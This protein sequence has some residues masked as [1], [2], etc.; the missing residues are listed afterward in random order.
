MI[1]ERINNTIESSND[2]QRLLSF[3]CQKENITFALNGDEVANEDVFTFN[4]L[5]PALAF[6]SF[7]VLRSPF[8][9]TIHSNEKLDMVDAM[10]P[11]YIEDKT[12]EELDCAVHFE[13][14]AVSLMLISNYLE[15]LRKRLA[16]DENDKKTSVEIELAPMVVTFKDAMD[17]QYI[18]KLSPQEATKKGIKTGII[19]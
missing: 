5:L 8:G 4:R 2:F 14:K 17:K 11:A 9:N 18:K 6:H 12:N 16:S 19:G 15:D 13:N 3:F 1:P 10:M 7:N